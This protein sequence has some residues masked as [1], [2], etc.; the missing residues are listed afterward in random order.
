ME[1]VNDSR[2]EMSAFYPHRERKQLYAFS[3]FADY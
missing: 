1:S 2:F 3:H